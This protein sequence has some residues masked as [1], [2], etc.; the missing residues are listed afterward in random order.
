MIS[1]AVSR[2]EMSWFKIQWVGEDDKKM[3]K[4]ATVSGLLKEGWSAN[5]SLKSQECYI[6]SFPHACIDFI[7]ACVKFNRDVQDVKLFTH[8]GVEIDDDELLS[9]PEV[10][11]DVLK[12]NWSILVSSVRNSGESNNLFLSFL[13]GWVIL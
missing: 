1:L 5:S 11:G 7:T 8:D 12:V 4:G 10:I 3:V 6:Y 13:S 9:E 2:S